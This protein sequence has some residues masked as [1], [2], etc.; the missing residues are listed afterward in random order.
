MT[1][2]C[3]FRCWCAFCTQEST[4][5]KPTSGKDSTRG[6]RNFHTL[7]DQVPTYL[8]DIL[9]RYMNRY[10]L[11]I[12]NNISGKNGRFLASETETLNSFCPPRFSQVCADFHFLQNAN[13]YKK[14]VW[15]FSSVMQISSNEKIYTHFL[16][17]FGF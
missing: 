17:R 2:T 7:Q 12:C 13:L 8:K 1:C 4:Q 9:Y 11:L 5:S 15:I 14:F 10:T 3:F 6:F 16:Y